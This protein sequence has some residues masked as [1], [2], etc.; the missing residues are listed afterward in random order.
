MITM[1]TQPLPGRLAGDADGHAV[2][3]IARSICGRSVLQIDSARDFATLQTWAQTEQRTERAPAE[4]AVTTGVLEPHLSQGGI[5]IR[6]MRRSG[7][8]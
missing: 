5:V 6:S 4:R 7:P 2:V 1:R 8:V 3:G